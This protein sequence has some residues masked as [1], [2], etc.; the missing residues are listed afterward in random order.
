LLLKVVRPLP[1][2]AAL[3]CHGAELP[4]QGF[5][6]GADV[7]GALIAFGGLLVCRLRLRCGIVSLAG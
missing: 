3:L 1:F 5:D 7:R 4:L 6:G 2:R